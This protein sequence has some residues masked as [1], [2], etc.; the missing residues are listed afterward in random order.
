MSEATRYKRKIVSMEVMRR[1]NAKKRIGRNLFYAF[2]LVLVCGVF[3]AFFFFTFFKIEKIEISGLS[4]YDVVD[5]AKTMNL[6]KKGNLYSFN[7]KNVEETIKNEYPY[8]GK[9]TIKQI[10]PSTVRVDI[11][12]KTAKFFVSIN[13]TYYLL[14]DDLLVVEEN[15]N[16]YEDMN[17]VELQCDDISYCIIGKKL[18]FFNSGSYEAFERV[19]NAIASQGMIEKIDWIKMET[20]FDIC[21]KY[22]DRIEVFIGDSE[23]VE[24]K[25]R[26]FREILKKLGEE[27]EG[28][29]NIVDP[30]EAS[31]KPKEPEIE[32]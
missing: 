18:R 5:I 22:D 31:F 14:S 29:L 2:V 8:L 16:G 12:E 26:F 10:P 3:V 17:L 15:P 24:V 11:V 6:T 21:F 25:M 30:K 7:A 9:V 19:Y 4:R 20:R 23:H 1:Q 13:N 28:Y 27:E 32:Y